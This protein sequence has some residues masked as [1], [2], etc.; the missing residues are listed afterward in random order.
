MP[1]IR[2]GPQASVKGRI[3]REKWKMLNFTPAMLRCMVLTQLIAQTASQNNT[4]Q[5]IDHTS[6]EGSWLPLALLSL[7][8]A[9]ALRIIIDFIRCLHRQSNKY[10]KGENMSKDPDAVSSRDSLT[11]S[12]PDIPAL[13][14]KC[15]FPMR[16]VDGNSQTRSRGN[17]RDPVVHISHCAVQT[18][19]HGNA[20]IS[21]RV[22]QFCLEKRQ[23]EVNKQEIDRVYFSPTAIANVQRQING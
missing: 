10:N 18:R 13:P 12:S 3:W 11:E 14:S 9:H 5:E 8:A 16:N 22:C 7:G 6:V 20:P 1:G 2:G 4:I 21:V 17:G 15:T 23:R 19:S